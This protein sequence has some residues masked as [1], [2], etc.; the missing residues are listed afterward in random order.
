[1]LAL[2]FNRGALHP[3]QPQPSPSASAPATPVA[4]PPLPV[5]PPRRSA[6]ADRFC[7]LLVDGLPTRL[8]DL[9]ARPVQ[10]ASAFVA[11]WGEPPVVLRCGVPR[12]P[13]FVVGAQTFVVEDV[14]WFVQQQAGRAVWTAVDRPV[15]VE[16]S[17]P[18]R[19]TSGPV[20]PI[21]DAVRVALPAQPIHPGP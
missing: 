19:Y 2:L 7:P 13:G 10:S 16:L 15:Y 18:L 21:A 8:H 17:V 14:T 1:M 5:V 6:A 4:L 3:R 20:V 9:D 11:A 12:P